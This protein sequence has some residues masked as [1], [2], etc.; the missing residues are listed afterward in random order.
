MCIHIY[1]SWLAI[2][3]SKSMNNVKPDCSKVVDFFIPFPHPPWFNIVKKSYTPGNRLLFF[4]DFLKCLL[5]FWSGRVGLLVLQNESTA[6]VQLT[7]LWELVSWD[8]ALITGAKEEK[9]GGGQRWASG[10]G[11][12]RIQPHC[13]GPKAAPAPK[14][15]PAVAVTW[16][17]LRSNFWS[18]PLLPWPLKTVLHSSTAGTLLEKNATD[19]NANALPGSPLPGFPQT[20]PGRGTTVLPPS[21][22][23]GL[24]PNRRDWPSLG[25][26]K[27]EVPITDRNGCI[28][29][30]LNL[31]SPCK[32]SSRLA[33]TKKQR[34]EGSGN[35]P[36]LV[37]Y[38]V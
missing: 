26:Q 6:L 24:Q 19:C 13:S 1:G 38:C 28:L 31:G 20:I 34:Q 16:Q 11:G 36:G 18:I 3:S 32:A 37:S 25:Y 30:N 4:Y 17:G 29:I 2:S 9:E 10:E 33:E 12:N 8:S 27:L 7:R 15:P 23:S 14:E 21:A 35:P 5:L 22:E